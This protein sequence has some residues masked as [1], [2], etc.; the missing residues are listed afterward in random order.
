MINYILDTK[1]KV[2]GIYV[3]RNLINGKIYIGQSKDLRQRLIAHKSL[4]KNINKNSQIIHKAIHKYGEENF[5]F[6]P[7][8]EKPYISRE[9]LN[10][11]EK[12]VIAEFI[13]TGFNMYNIA[14]GGYAGDLGKIVRE[15]ISKKLKNRKFT[16]EWR[17][18]ISKSLKGKKR[19]IEQIEKAK[20][21]YKEKFKKGLYKYK[22]IGKKEI[23]HPEK[24]HTAWNKGLTKETDERVAKYS[25][26]L[27]NNKN[28]V[29]R[30]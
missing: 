17:E 6:C 16:K 24:S 14:D 11:L 25:I 22:G 5:V 2:A 8:I 13:K 1:D 26:K 27:K 23:I 12:E 19:P 30:V 21:T 29:N 3:I 28:R 9:R 10:E 15:K 20:I 7:L 4:S 18:K